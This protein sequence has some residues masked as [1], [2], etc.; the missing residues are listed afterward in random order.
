MNKES[1]AQELANLSWLLDELK[2]SCEDPNLRWK[3]AQLASKAEELHEKFLDEF[4]LHPLSPLKHYKEL[5]A[6]LSA[7]E[8]IEALISF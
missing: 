6:K 4:N 8:R 5:S 7:N 3:I 1:T 2:I